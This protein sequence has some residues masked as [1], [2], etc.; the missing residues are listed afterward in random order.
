MQEPFK[1]QEECEY[2]YLHAQ[3]SDLDAGIF[4][5]CPVSVLPDSFT[6]LGTCYD[7]LA[8]RDSGPSLNWLNDGVYS[9][10]QA[11]DQ[12]CVIAIKD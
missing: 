10:V 1:A 4:A 12:A 2:V 8:D 11:E 3:L 5:L 6:K 9:R 7:N